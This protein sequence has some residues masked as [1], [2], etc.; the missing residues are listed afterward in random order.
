[1]AQAVG[2]KHQP[3]QGEKHAGETTKPT[4]Q[5]HELSTESTA[6]APR[7]AQIRKSRKAAALKNTTKVLQIISEESGVASE[8]LTDDSSFADLG[9]DSLLSMII[10]SRIQEEIGINT[11]S[12]EFSD[13]PTVKHLKEFLSKGEGASQVKFEEEEEEEEEAISVLPFKSD[14]SQLGSE[15]ATTYPIGPVNGRNGN[16]DFERI[17][18]IVSE[19]T[20]VSVDDLTDD[21]ALVEL[22]VDEVLRLIIA[23]RCKE[24]F[25]LDVETS[26]LFVDVHT[27]KD[28]KKSVSVLIGE[29]S[30]SVPQTKATNLLV[31]LVHTGSRRFSHEDSTDSYSSQDSTPSSFSTTSTVSGQGQGTTPVAMRTMVSS[32][33]KEGDM[34]VKPASVNLRSAS[35]VI[36]QGRPQ[37][38]KK[39]LFLFADG[40]G[41]ASS[42]SNL[43]KVN[44]EL[45]IIGLNSPYVR[46]PEEMTCTLDQLIDKYIT[47]LRRRQPVGPYHLGG[48][49]AGGILAYRAAQYFVRQG[50]EV[51]TLVLIDSP[52]PKGLDKLP[53]RFMEHCQQIGLWKGTVQTSRGA[54]PK[55][56][57]AHFIATMNILRHFYAEPLPKSTTL[58]CSILFA[59]ES[60][61]T[62]DKAF[63]PGDDVVEDMTFLTEKR[64][65]FTP[66]G[67][68]DLIP[69]GEI[70]VERLEGSHHFSMM[71]GDAVKETARF[72]D[73]A[74][75]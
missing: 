8:D 42:Y 51:E 38:C 30:R 37:D 63:S 50:E 21:S 49:S 41:S 64:T 40:A 20:G 2:Q 16:I 32:D 46:F 13:H 14:P 26:S 45:A 35:S 74:M 56:L 58:R 34:G 12:W 68:R 62:E 18:Q 53:I 39:I 55:T 22:G 43:P 72:I 65:D 10:S 44:S 23:G 29:V 52:V 5:P 69:G 27:V 1:M 54:P 57:F 75:R 4:T 15:S 47:E 70:V 31:P 28:L 6:K 25:G 48:W 61:F 36:V 3:K 9:V 24:S 19:E 73:R 60:I 7:L 59:T 66:G 67:W 11:D 17:V 71:Q 33:M